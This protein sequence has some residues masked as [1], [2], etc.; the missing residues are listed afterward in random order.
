MSSKVTRRGF[1]EKSLVTATAVTPCKAPTMRKAIF[2]CGLVVMLSVASAHKSLLAEPTTPS[3]FDV[4]LDVVKQGLHPDFCWFH[5]RV[6]PIPGAGRDGRPAVVMTLQKHLGV[7]D[8]YSG[9][10]M[11]RTDDLG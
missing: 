7:S 10:W 5:P 6:A 1:L 2:L 8:H 4:R 3:T 9:L 11:M